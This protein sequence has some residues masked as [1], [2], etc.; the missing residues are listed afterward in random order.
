MNKRI[1]LGIDTSISPQT[2]RA[3]RVV[4]A[5]MEQAAPEFHVVLLSVIPVPYM[6]SPSLGMYV[7]HLLPMSITPE[8][9]SQAED[10]LRRA[11]TELQ[12]AGVF[13]EQIEV[14]IRI[15]IPAEEIVKVAKELQ[16][17]FIVV[18]SHGN[19]L[20]QKIRRFFAGSTSRRVLQLAP[21]PVMI[22][23]TPDT[24][25]PADLVTWYV[26][27]IT[28]YLQQ[29]TDVLTVFTPQEVAKKFLPPNKKRP[30]RKEIAAATLALEQL[31]GSGML[32]RHDVSG[33]L[34]YVND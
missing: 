29:N 30:G 11:R 3:L 31:T 13:A 26:D 7:G 18:G 19:A 17:T 14:L 34:K 15:G 20:R 4:S 1:L 5:F 10:D 24:P 12:K 22:T 21:C 2:Q 23:S 16:V 33:E 25:R 6:T 9:R 32:C 28:V 8:Q 27:A